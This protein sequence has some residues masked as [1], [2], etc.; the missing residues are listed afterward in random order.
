[1]FASVSS[2]QFNESLTSAEQRL[3]FMRSLVS[4]G[5]TAARDSGV[6]D[7]LLIT[8]EPDQ[9]LSVVIYESEADIPPAITVASKV[10]TQHF[11]DQLTLL[12]RERGPLYEAQQLLKPDEVDPPDG[13]SDSDGLGAYVARWQIDPSLESAEVEEW[14]RKTWADN[15]DFLRE[16]GLLDRLVI[17]VASDQLLV[18]NLF[19]VGMDGASVYHD[20]IARRP[21]MIYRK[22]AL[23]S[24]ETGRA[25]DIPALTG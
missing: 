9:M 23:I 8:L 18:V 20:A 3:H 25:Y 14:V 22:V 5:I 10:M 24:G 16:L 21:S 1:M 17:R 13:R 4:H 19:P 7:F 12:G 11:P 2:W 15:Q 6:L